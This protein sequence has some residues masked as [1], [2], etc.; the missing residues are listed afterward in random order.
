MAPL[1]E[2]AKWNRKIGSGPQTVAELVKTFVQNAIH[3]RGTIG[4]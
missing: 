1:R 4:N 2:I 3:G